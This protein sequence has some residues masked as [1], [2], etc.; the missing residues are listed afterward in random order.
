[1]KYYEVL[2]EGNDRRSFFVEA[3]NMEKAAGEALLKFIIEGK[4]C[5]DEKSEEYG[6][7]IRDASE[8]AKKFVLAVEKDPA[9]ADLRHGLIKLCADHNWNEYTTAEVID[10]I[11]SL[12]WDKFNHTDKIKFSDIYSLEIGSTTGDFNMNCVELF[13]QEAIKMHEGLRKKVDGEDNLSEF[14]EL[15]L[16]DD[17]SFRAVHCLYRIDNEGPSTG[18]YVVTEYRFPK[19]GNY[20]DLIEDIGFD[21]FLRE[22]GRAH[23]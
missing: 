5:E 9:L 10:L 7:F 11:D 22:I 14:Y 6:I 3:E 12:P 20:F 4:S 21:E 19:S 16:L 23:V 15:F 2:F 1:M 8:D 17:F 13:G 18:E